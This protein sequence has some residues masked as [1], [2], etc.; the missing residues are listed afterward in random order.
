MQNNIII[1]CYILWEPRFGKP[2]V[3]RLI[4]NRLINYVMIDHLI[5]PICN[6]ILF[7]I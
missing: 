7:K 1:I 2:R 3:N 6:Y 4:V 5:I